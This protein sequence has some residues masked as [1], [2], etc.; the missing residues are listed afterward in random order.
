M[1]SIMSQINKN[2]DNDEM[3]LWK[4]STVHSE[5]ALLFAQTILLVGHILSAFNTLAYQRGLNI[6]K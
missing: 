1:F 3:R 6:R 4:T 2:G 5:P